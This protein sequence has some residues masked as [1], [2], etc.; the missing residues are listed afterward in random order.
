MGRPKSDNPKA[1]QLTVRLDDETL[2]KLDENAKHHQES[3]AA[4]LRRGIELI[5]QAIE[6]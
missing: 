2:A 6:K 1:T 5:N 3:R 4:S